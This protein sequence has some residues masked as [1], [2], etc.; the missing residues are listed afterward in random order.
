MAGSIYN[1]EQPLSSLQIVF[2][3]WKNPYAKDFFCAVLWN[4]M[5]DDA[6]R[7]TPRNANLHYSCFLAL[8][9]ASWRLVQ[10][11]KI[12][13]FEAGL[14]QLASLHTNEGSSSCGCP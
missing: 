10:M 5:S 1:W 6:G 14:N 9:L 7:A 11:W 13:G 12:C 8:Y 4:V 2:S 3:H